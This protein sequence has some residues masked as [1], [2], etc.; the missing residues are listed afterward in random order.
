MAVIFAASSRSDVST[1]ARVPDWITH[2]GEYFV[3]G[4]LLCRA[5]AGGF[6]APLPLGSGLLSVALGAA[7][8]VSDE[9]HQSFVAGRE[10][11]VADV[12]KDFGGCSAGA[13]AHLLR[14][15]KP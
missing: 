7:W 4:L 6:R 8:G 9:W 2:G 10:A 1:L 14:S 12:A 15:R 5:L 3:L 11:S 13:L